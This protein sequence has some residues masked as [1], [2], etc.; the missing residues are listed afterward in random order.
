MLNYSAKGDMKRKG[1]KSWS[2]GQGLASSARRRGCRYQEVEQCGS[3]PSQEL[4]DNG[5]YVWALPVDLG[6]NLKENRLDTAECVGRRRQRIKRKKE[7]IKREAGGD[8]QWWRRWRNAQVSEINSSGT[9]S[10][11]W[12]S[13]CRNSRRQGAYPVQSTAAVLVKHNEG[14]TPKSR[15]R[16]S[17][18]LAIHSQMCGEQGG[19]SDAE[20]A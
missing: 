12:S 18:I 1:W 5:A 14:S 10:F 20:K 4:V 3:G 16:H 2:V 13:C 17:S 9:N 19:W 15:G 6:R 8:G 11:C 7:M